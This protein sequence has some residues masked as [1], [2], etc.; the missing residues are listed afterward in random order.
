MFFKLKFPTLLN[1]PFLIWI[2]AK[3]G[4]ELDSSSDEIII[5]LL[6]IIFTPSIWDLLKGSLTLIILSLFNGK[7]NSGIK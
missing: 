6:D 3:K 7:L 2:L 4:L 1:N 5:K